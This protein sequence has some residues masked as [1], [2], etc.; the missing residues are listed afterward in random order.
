MSFTEKDVE[1]L[2]PVMDNYLDDYNKGDNKWLEERL[3]NDLPDNNV[4]DRD[5]LIKEID[6]GI[7]Q[8]DDTL[9]SLRES[10]DAGDTKEEWLAEKLAQIPGVDA[11]ESKDV[12]RQLGAGIH[13]STVKDLAMS[14]G[15]SLAEKIPLGGNVGKLKRVADALR[16]GQDRELKQAASAALVTAVQKGT[17]PI[18][19]NTPVAA[20]AA[21]ASG[22]VETAKVMQKYA[23]GELSG[24]EAVNQMEEVATAQTAQIIGAMAEKTGNVLG[25][26]LGI[27]I[28]NL[29]PCLR[30]A[31]PIISSITSYICGM[32]GRVAG[33]KI[34]SGI[35]MA[36]RNLKK[37]ATPMVESI[38]EKIKNI[39][40][41][42]L[43]V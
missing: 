1:K 41:N 26:N 35:F 20:L 9:S 6:K 43:D 38:A 25:A 16:S 31:Q 39:R 17:I 13:A 36:A 37:I 32:V 28:S 30:P 21:L 42:L 22:G 10:L 12:S 14:V 23:D 15:L 8:Y 7:S 5:E 29:H 2:Q 27:F 40:N 11:E 19:K 33:E 18:P 3:K 24:Q 4:Q 34:S